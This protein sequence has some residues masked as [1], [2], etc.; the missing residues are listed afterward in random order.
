MPHVLAMPAGKL[1][2][3]VAFVILVEPHDLAGGVGHGP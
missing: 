2:D 3:P 1:G